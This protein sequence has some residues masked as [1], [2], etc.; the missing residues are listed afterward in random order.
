MNYWSKNSKIPSNGS[1]PRAVVKLAIFSALLSFFLFP[2]DRILIAV[3]VIYFLPSL[4]NLYKVGCPGKAFTLF[5]NLI[6]GWTII[7]WISLFI[8][9]ISPFGRRE[10]Y[11][12]EAE[13][14]HVIVA[15]IISE[16]IEIIKDRDILTKENITDTSINDALN[17]YANF[18]HEIETVLI[19]IKNSPTMGIIFTDYGIYA[20]QS[21]YG[22]WRCNYADIKQI[23]II[24]NKILIND[25]F[26]IKLPSGKS[27][28]T[29]RV[30][31][32]MI[33]AIAESGNDK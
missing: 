17:N 14:D 11:R 9:A 10:I 26:V 25:I 12:V 1:L 3:L 19:F 28:E 32:E 15:D 20:N 16:Y 29:V 24:G 33:V 2:E 7:F 8:D 21:F 13:L 30:F 31:F 22:E 18:Y 23:I 27:D 5:L 4:I 6:G